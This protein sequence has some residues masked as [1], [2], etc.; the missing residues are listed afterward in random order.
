MSYRF[1]VYIVVSLTF[2]LSLSG[3]QDTTRL[4]KIAPAAPAIPTQYDTTQALD[5][6]KKGL[7]ALF[8]TRA[9]RRSKL[10]GKVYSITR[11]KTLWEKN[12]NTPRTPASV[13]K[14]FTT[15]AGFYALG[16][17]GV[18]TTEIRATGSI[19]SDGTL[20]GDL[21]FVG[22][23]DAS[24][25]VNHIEEMADNLFAIGIR[26]INGTIYGDP[27][28]FDNQ[29][30][31]AIYSGDGED[32][33]RLRPVTALTHSE[34]EISVVVSATSKGY[35]SVQTIPASDAFV[36]V[37]R[38]KRRSRRS[39]IRIS[40]T[41]LKDGR[42]KIVVSGSPGANATKTYKIDMR[43]PSLAAAGTLSN[44]LRS[45]G[46]MNDTLIGVRAAPPEARVLTSYEHTFTAFASRVNKR[47]D[48]YLAEHVF[49]MV[50][51]LYGGQENTAKVA[52]RMVLA[53][54]DSMGVPRKGAVFN[55]G[56]G[57]SRRN[58]VSANTVVALLEKIH[59]SPYSSDFHSTMSLAGVDGT[60][61]GRML[62]TPADSNVHAKTGTLRHVSAL[63]GYVYTL[64]GELLAFA[65]L[66]N[67]PYKRTFKRTEDKAAI[68][69][70][71]LTY[72]K[73]MK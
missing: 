57:L 10:S 37:S 67:G 52:K 46:I 73:A 40:S 51:A 71:E 30:N 26:R 58:L 59:Q 68:L 38:T 35:V 39:R 47:S 22:A 17:E 3:A 23:G 4:P 43:S 41:V 53:T 6:L 64:D 54:L 56:S 18:M 21:Y 1:V 72:R 50:G 63:A 11:G 70:S 34:G 62:N 28:F 55:D 19:E 2:I 9:Y 66:S 32:V 44:R 16:K 20:N 14:L 27:S 31:R 24:L 49:K 65:F 48:N 60:I 69:L 45:G 29:T 13:T 7:N 12:P 36:L 25:T 15:N 5:K 33:V 8:K 42:Q 61:R